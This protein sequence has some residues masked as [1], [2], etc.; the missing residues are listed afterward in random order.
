MLTGLAIERLSKTT[1]LDETKIVIYYFFDFIRKESMLTLTFLRSILHQLID[2]LISIDKLDPNIQ[3]SLEQ[4]FMNSSGQTEPQVEELEKLMLECCARYKRVYFLIDGI[5]EADQVNKR[6]IF[7]FLKKIQLYCP[8]V[9]LFISGQLDTI[10]MKAFGHNQVFSIK[11]KSQDLDSDI[12]VFTENQIE[13]ERKF[14]VLTNCL[15]EL[16]GL[17]KQFLTSHAHGM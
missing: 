3:Q 11:I 14:G 8:S 4:L 17:I 15:P 2:C 6:Y 12:R 5:D 7:R 16:I 9:K 1:R 13:H 10:T